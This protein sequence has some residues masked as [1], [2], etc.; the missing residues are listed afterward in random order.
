MNKKITAVS[1]IFLSLILSFIFYEISRKAN[2]EV[3]VEE[4]EVIS[5]AFVKNNSWES[6]YTTDIPYTKGNELEYVYIIEP[7][8]NKEAEIDI[9]KIWERVE[10]DTVEIN[11][12]EIDVINNKITVDT[13]E[14]QSIKIK[15]TAKINKTEE[16]NI[17]EN[18]EVTVKEKKENAPV[19]EESEEIDKTDISNLSLNTYSFSSNIDSLLIIT[20]ENIESIS[21][22]TIWDY[23]F[24]PVFKDWK[25]FFNLEAKTFDTWEYFWIIKQTNWKIITLDKKLNFTLIKEE[26]AIV[27]ISPREIWNDKQNY[28]VLQ[29]DWFDK[30]I[31]LQL[32]NNVVIKNTQFEILTDKVMPVK[33][34]PNL[35]SWEYHFNIMT[36]K[37]IVELHSQK[38]KIIHKD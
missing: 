37:W 1:V 11:W 31:S 30:V 6:D 4:K 36:T 16:E 27:N 13:S 14:A 28:L 34:P 21:A 5:E 2:L 38:F 17:D 23:S 7:Q 20:W 12:E 32:S 8:E 29:W 24:K 35:P 15:G 10:V 25:A 22:L 3:E 19:I 26:V 33:I 18:I 9:S